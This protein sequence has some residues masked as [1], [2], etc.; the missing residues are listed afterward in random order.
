MQKVNT[1][2]TEYLNSEETRNDMA[3]YFLSS[4]YVYQFDGKHLSPATTRVDWVLL[5][6]PHKTYLGFRPHSSD[7]EY[8]IVIP[9]D[10]DGDPEKARIVCTIFFRLCHEHSLAPQTMPPLLN[11]GGGVHAL[12][13]I[14]RIKNTPATAWAIHELYKEYQLLFEEAKQEAGIVDVKLDSCFDPARLF[15][16]AGTR[17][18]KDRTFTRHYFE[19]PPD[20]VERFEPLAK[21]I[22]EKAK[23]YVPFSVHSVKREEFQDTVIEMLEERYRSVIENIYRQA[24][25]YKKLNRDGERDRSAIFA[26]LVCT[27]MNVLRK[28]GH[29]RENAEKIVFACKHV[30]NETASQ[31]RPLKYHEDLERQIERLL[32]DFVW[33]GGSTLKLPPQ[34]TI[35]EPP[36]KKERKVCV[37]QKTIDALSTFLS[38]RLYYLPG[39]YVSKEIVRQTFEE[40]TGKTLSKMQFGQLTTGKQGTYPETIQNIQSHTV[41]CIQDHILLDSVETTVEVGPIW[42][43]IQL[44]DMTFYFVITPKQEKIVTDIHSVVS[45]KNDEK[46]D[47]REENE[48]VSQHSRGPPPS[49][50]I[51]VDKYYYARS[52][53]GR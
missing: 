53:E 37:D 22:L 30:L 43:T 11:S 8:I 36:K 47:E 27:L 24:K 1:F 9:F 15:S 44:T 33:H 23:Q 39:A 21:K 35:I 41:R 16:M 51:E 17:R 20:T 7:I 5:N 38:N 4:R 28:K 34:Q 42:P 40:E 19:T 25:L 14:P 45:F 26:S 46:L 2:S 10:I 3:R 48:L 12:L 52:R 6:T 29:T 18:V 50:L 31:G 13:P 32:E 49:T